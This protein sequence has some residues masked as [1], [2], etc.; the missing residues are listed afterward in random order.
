MVGPSG[1][2]QDTELVEL[3]ESS[4][5]SSD[6]YNGD[7][8]CRYHHERNTVMDRYSKATRDSGHLEIALSASQATLVVVEGETNV[9]RA[10]LAASD[11][12]V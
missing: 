4:D 12:G 2:A 8:A 11:G 3:I 7:D 1:T 10:Q 6:S 9:V 5:E